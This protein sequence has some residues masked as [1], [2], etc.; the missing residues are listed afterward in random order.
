[1]NIIKQIT[2]SRLTFKE[3][4]KDEWDV[5]MIQD[6]S[7]NEISKMYSTK[8]DAEITFGE[9]SGCNFVITHKYL[10]WHKLHVIYYNFPEIGKSS[11]KITKDCAKK[12]NSLYSTILEPE[13][14]VIVIITEP[15]TE[16]LSNAFEELY[17]Q[18][19]EYLEDQ[20]ETKHEFQN[21]SL[22]HI[23][24]IHIFQL[25]HITKDIR[26]NIYVPKHEI[27]RDNLEINKILNDTNS[28][29]TQL[30]IIQRTDI[31]AKILRIAPGDLC[32]IT[33]V[34]ETGG[35]LPYFRICK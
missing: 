25:S 35:E 1:M 22:R 15:I 31:Q 20:Y 16:N 33:R 14:S 4:L 6:Y 11:V 26:K 13:D 9:A 19:Q 5:S 18:G 29:K 7:E 3:Y 34:T 27:I 32:K 12:I 10:K 21:Y 30:P 2:Q 23:R 24:N 28:N 17:I 8:K